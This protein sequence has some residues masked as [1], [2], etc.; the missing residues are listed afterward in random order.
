[1]RLDGMLDLRPSSVESA[2][3]LV[4]AKVTGLGGHCEPQP[5]SMRDKSGLDGD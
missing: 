5:V 4:Q 2:V 3:S 1:M